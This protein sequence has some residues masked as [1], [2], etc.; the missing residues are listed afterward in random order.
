ME[1]KKFKSPK[2]EHELIMEKILRE[3]E[4]QI[5]D[6]PLSIKDSEKIIKEGYKLLEKCEELRKSRDKWRNKFTAQ[7]DANSTKSE[8]LHVN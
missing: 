5:L 2:C 1:N 4:I 7:N 8:N 6:M 3:A